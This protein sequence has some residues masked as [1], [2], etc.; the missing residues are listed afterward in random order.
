MNIYGNWEENVVITLVCFTN[1]PSFIKIDG[2]RGK[3]GREIQRE[4]KGAEVCES[5][6]C[7]VKLTEKK[8]YRAFF[9]STE[10]ETDEKEGRKNAAAGKESGRRL[11]GEGA[12]L[13]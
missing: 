13:L 10:N 4:R 12:G 1:S 9:G 5:S 3:R 6:L 11:R 8:I 7:N 2:W